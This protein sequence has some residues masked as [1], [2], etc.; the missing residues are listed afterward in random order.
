MEIALEQWFLT[1]LELLSVR[2][3]LKPL[4]TPPFLNYKYEKGK[5]YFII[6]VCT[7]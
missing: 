2:H 1:S 4:I 3:T 5:S 6:K 7:K